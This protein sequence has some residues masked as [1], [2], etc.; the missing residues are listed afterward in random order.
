MKSVS[1]PWGNVSISWTSH[2]LQYCHKRVCLVL[3][4]ANSF[5]FFLSPS[6]SSLKLYIFLRFLYN[7]SPTYENALS[8]SNLIF[9]FHLPLTS[10]DDHIYTKSCVIIFGVLNI[11]LVLNIYQNKHSFLSSKT[12]SAL[13]NWHG[14]HWQIFVAK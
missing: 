1:A 7:T 5:F 11:S 2:V 6:N 3:F 14:D 9:F 8:T 13:S 10:K 12:R 4:S